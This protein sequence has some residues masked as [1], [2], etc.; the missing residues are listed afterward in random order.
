VPIS[1]PQKPRLRGVSHQYAFFAS[2]FAGAGLVAAASG[3]AEVASTA[4]FATALAVM[5]ATSAVYHRIDWRPAARRWLRRADHAAIFLLI[6]GTYTPFGVLV[7]DG[8]WRI[9]VLAI[10][11][12]GCLAAIAVKFLWLDA[13]KWLSAALAIALGWVGIVALP[14][15]VAATGIGAVALLG[16]GGI[17]YTAGA[18]VYARR[19]PDPRPAV[20]GYHE[21]F[22]ALVIA[23][24]ACQ[25]AA[26]T[27]F[28]LDV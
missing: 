27:F 21:L 11:W 24:A 20:F 19:R 5:F 23:A 4:V 6:A 7:L 3:G 18:V 22:H 10:V 26:I 28:V 2:L 12:S 1:P 16:A 9:T 25:Y 13:P 8:A 15:L 14:K 17:F